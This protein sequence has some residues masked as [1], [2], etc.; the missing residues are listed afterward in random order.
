MGL[1]K[2]P[3]QRWSGIESNQ[4]LPAIMLLYS[5][6]GLTTI[7]LNPIHQPSKRPMTQFPLVFSCT[8]VHSLTLTELP[9]KLRPML[10]TTV[11]PT[12]TSLLLDA[13]LGSFPSNSTQK[14]L[15]MAIGPCPRINP[16]T[17]NVLGLRPKSSRRS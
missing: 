5:F 13:K 8:L 12:N 4:Y 7:K 3:R 14:S 11:L 17:L 16:S 9:V 15:P 1:D 2:I 6:H 10:R